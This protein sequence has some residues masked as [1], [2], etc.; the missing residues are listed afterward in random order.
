MF[1]RIGFKSFISKNVDR[2]GVEQVFRPAVKLDKTFGF[3]R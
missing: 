3:S 2:D 1:S